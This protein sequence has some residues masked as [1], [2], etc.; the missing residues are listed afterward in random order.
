[1]ANGTF[2][3]RCIGSLKGGGLSDNIH[4]SQNRA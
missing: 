4:S 3:D 1:M 2:F